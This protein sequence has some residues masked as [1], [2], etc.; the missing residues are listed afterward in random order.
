MAYCTFSLSRMET[1]GPIMLEII[2]HQKATQVGLFFSQMCSSC[3]FKRF[4][5]NFHFQCHFFSIE[6]CQGQVLTRNIADGKNQVDPKKR[7]E[8]FQMHA[9]RQDK[10][11]ID[12]NLVNPFSRKIIRIQI[13]MPRVFHAKFKIRQILK[14]NPEVKKQQQR[15]ISF[16]YSFLV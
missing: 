14:S 12:K 5:R 15:I 7:Q 16:F 9:T 11:L 6:A 8:K 4:G 2:L 10:I 1:I 3:K 13:K